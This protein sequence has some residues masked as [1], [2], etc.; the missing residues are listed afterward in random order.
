MKNVLKVIP[1][2]NEI[3]ELEPCDNTTLFISGMLLHKRVRHVSDVECRMNDSLVLINIYD[4]ER[5]K[6][7]LL[8]FDEQIYIL[9]IESVK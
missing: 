8:V 5:E 7:Y 1:K 6:T 2:I 9:S 4:G 3:N